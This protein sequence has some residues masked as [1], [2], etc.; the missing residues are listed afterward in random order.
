MQGNYSQRLEMQIPQENTY[1]GPEPLPKKNFTIEKFLKKH[2]RF[3][4]CNFDEISQFIISDKE[5][6]KLIRD[7]PEILSKELPYCKLSI[8]FMKET[9]PNEKIL[10][11]LIY[12]D[13]ES[14][15]LLQK[16]DLICDMLIDRY[17]Q[18]RIEYIILVETYEKR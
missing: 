3:P 11:I 4:S 14:E 10:E 2:F 7:L 5:M 15:Q 12:S 8:D 16:E 17:P 18:T 13:L 1:T 6:E 9:D